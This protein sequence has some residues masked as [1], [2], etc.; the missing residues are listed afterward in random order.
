MKLPMYP[1]PRNAAVN[2]GLTVHENNVFEVVGAT[3]IGTPM[4]RT[5]TLATKRSQR[6]AGRVLRTRSVAS[7]G[8]VTLNPSGHETSGTTRNV[9][10]GRCL[11]AAPGRDVAGASASPS[12]LGLSGRRKRHIEESYQ[13]PF[14]R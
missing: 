5:R 6:S 4:I 7:V 2:G 8:T 10:A 3:N 13:Q 9:M 14:G 11:A 12:L 1:A